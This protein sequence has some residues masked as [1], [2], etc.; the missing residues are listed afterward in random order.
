MLRQL[1]PALEP[2]PFQVANRFLRRDDMLR[3]GLNAIQQRA[4]MRMSDIVLLICLETYL[5][6]L[7]MTFRKSHIATDTQGQQLSALL[8]DCLRRRKRLEGVSLARSV[9]QAVGEWIH[10]NVAGFGRFGEAIWV[11]EE[12]WTR[13]PSGTPPPAS[14]WPALEN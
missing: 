7:G 14:P 10:C 3:G 13:P 2:G 1:Q 12:L 8:M 4:N 5:P 9:A 6:E 11:G